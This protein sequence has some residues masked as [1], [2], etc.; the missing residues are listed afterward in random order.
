MSTHNIPFS[1][2][3]KKITVNYPKSAAM[4][5]FLG[6]QERFHDSLGKQAISVQAVEV[7]LYIEF[8]FSQFSADYFETFYR[9]HKTIQ[10]TLCVDQEHKNA[11]KDLRRNI[12]DPEFWIMSM[13]LS[14]DLKKGHSISFCGR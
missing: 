7:L 10:L 12:C 3:K 13:T 8:I 9:C 14:Y 11:I 5:F 1:I 4:G 6:T 2:I